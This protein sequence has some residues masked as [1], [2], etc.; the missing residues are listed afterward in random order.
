VNEI[1]T[2][3]EQN[4]KIILVKRGEIPSREKMQASG[5]H[6]SEWDW[7]GC[8]FDHTIENDSTLENLNTN[9]DTLIHQLQDH[10]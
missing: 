9:I 1:K 5:A 6:Q 3:R 4:G 10:Q 2:I 7:I 8:E